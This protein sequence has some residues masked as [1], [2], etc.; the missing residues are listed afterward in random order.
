MYQS[1]KAAKIAKEMH[2]YKIEVMGLSETVT[3]DFF[4]RRDS[5][6]CAKPPTWRARDFTVKVSFL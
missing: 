2:K 3:V 4:T 1:G 6:S 5:W